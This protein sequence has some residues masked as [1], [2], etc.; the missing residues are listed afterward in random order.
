MKALH[1]ILLALLALAVAACANIG[2]PEGG[3]AD[4]TPPVVQRTSP[5]NGALNF[6][7]NKVE[8][9]FDE[10]VNIKEQQ[11]K[12]VVSPTQHD[13]PVIKALGKKVTVEFRDT[14][15]PATTYVVDFSNAIEDN[16][17]GNPLDGYSFTFSTGPTIDSLRISGI[18]L[19]AATLE[20]AQYVVVGLHSCLDDTAFT[21]Q[22][23]E[24]ITRTNDRG[25]FTLMGLKEGTYHIFALNDIDANNLMS[26]NE[27]YAFL[28]QTVTPTATLFTSNDTTFTFDHRVDTVLVATHTE[29]L[30]NNVLLSIFNEKYS[31]LYLKTTSRPERNKLYVQLSTTCDTLPELR[32]IAPVNVEEEWYRL[33]RNV[34]N[35]SLYYWL[36][37]SALIASD[38]LT[39]VMDYLHTDSTEQITWKQD[40]ITF[41][42]RKSSQQLKDE[43]RQKKEEEK[44][45]KRIAHLQEKQQQGKEL[46]EEEQEELKAEVKPAVKKMRVEFVKHGSLEIYD[47]L[48]VKVDAPLKYFEPGGL[49]LSMK[50]DSLWIPL[51][52]E[53]SLV[54]RDAYDVLT[55]VLPLPLDADSTYR[56]VIDAGALTSVY[57][58][59]CDSLATEFKVKAPEEYSNLIVNVNVRDSAF[60]DLLGSQEKI[61]SRQPVSGGQAQF[62]NVTPGTYYLRLTLDANGN[63]QWD[64]GS[65]TLHRQPE[66]VYYYPKPLRLRKGWDVEQQWN[67]YETALDLQKPDDIRRNKPEQD[68]SR[69]NKMNSG[70]NK[71]KNDNEEDEDEFNSTGFG[72]G[73]YSGDKYRDYQQN[74]RR[75]R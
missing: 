75:N 41:A 30:P 64:P 4:Y 10:I 34:R 74:R 56:F 22:P 53:P 26:R 14:L 17:E 63:G 73:A 11:K 9:V 48:M 3:P 12:V 28:D 72:N 38:S 71:K 35:D 65:Y 13:M 25:Q 8:I 32:P 40:T 68:K 2:S 50:R 37:D 20:P 60:I 43:A 21:R 66:E 33:E 45:L 39:V 47:S 27:S 31:P 6:K 42:Y 15:Q 57:G 36:T 44:R 58:H 24:R 67:I 1:H 52:V 69:L 16:N 59:S 7:G 19:D 70:K 46:N 61:L 55:Y 62:D 18:V 29:F 54:P 51:D 5:I 23:F 49:H